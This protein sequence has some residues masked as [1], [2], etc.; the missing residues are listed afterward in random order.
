M[1]TG[2]VFVIWSLACVVA[3]W[4]LASYFMARAIRRIMARA[5]KE[6]LP[7]PINVRVQKE[8]NMFYVYNKDTEAF[9]VQGVD[10]S[11][12]A[13]KLVANFPGKTFI[14][15]PNDLREVGYIKDDAI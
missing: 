8:G 5:E 6:Q 15:N 10:E 12:V 13:A 11:D 7:E 1:I 14:A 9:I 4:L 2:L 3:G